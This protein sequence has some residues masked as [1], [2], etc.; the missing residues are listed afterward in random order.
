MAFGDSAGGSSSKPP[1]KQVRL[2]SEQNANLGEDNNGH[3]KSSSK[4]DKKKSKDP[5]KD[6][7]GDQGGS[8]GQGGGSGAYV[9]PPDFFSFN[10]PG[11]GK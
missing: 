3:S 4:G 8:S 1:E 2:C 6:K 7:S 11:N 10:D 5:N 9:S